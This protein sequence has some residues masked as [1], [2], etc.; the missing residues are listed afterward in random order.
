MRL[1]FYAI[2]SIRLFSSSTLI[3]LAGV[4]PSRVA[5]ILFFEFL[6]L[7]EVFF[8]AS[9][10]KVSIKSFLGSLTTIAVESG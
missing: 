3:T 4:A 6:I 2:S 10:I 8:E 5:A 9:T 1:L 7:K